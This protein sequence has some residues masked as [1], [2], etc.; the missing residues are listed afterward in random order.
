MSIR[1]R[2][3]LTILYLSA[4]AVLLA[5]LLDQTK[6]FRLIA[7]KAADLNYLAV[8]SHAP[9]EITLIVVDQRTMDAFSEPRMFWHGYYAEAIEAAAAAGA[10]VLGLDLAFAIPVEK[11]T[12][13]LDQR[14]AEAVIET[15]RV[16]P[17]ICAY[18]GTTMQKQADWPVPMNMAAAALGQ[19]AYVNLTADEDD[20]IRSIELVEAGSGDQPRMRSM[21]LE[22]ADRYLGHRVAYPS[23]L[24]TIR[25]A[26]PA[27]TIRRISLV[28]F[29]AAARAHNR[30]LLQSW[31]GG[32]A[33][34]LGTDEIGDRHA[35]PYYAFRVGWP[36][37]TAG[38]EI[39]ANALDTLL[40]GRFLR[41]APATESLALMLVV[42]L[43][44][45]FTTIFTTGWRLIMWHTALTATLM[46]GSHLA[47]RAGWLV[48]ASSLLLTAVIA[49]LL[50]VVAGS[51]T[52]T[53]N[54]DAL[55][56]AMRLF[57]GKEV[58]DDV[59]TTGMVGLSGRREFATVLFSDIRGFTAFS[60]THEP[61]VVVA[62][63]NAY[64]ST[65]TGLIV[66]H[67]GKVNKFIG[68]G[69]L[70]VFSDE[71]LISQRGNAAQTTECHAVRAIRCAIEMVGSPSA[72]ETRTGIHSG[73]VVVGNIG[74]SDKLENT[75]LGDTV[76]LASRLEGLNRQFST[77]VLFS[78]TTRE[79]LGN[80]IAA[81]LLGE[82]NVKGK[83][84]AVPVYTVA[85]GEGS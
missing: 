81:R 65:M 53:R 6:L 78:G 26:G 40:S 70:A 56:I 55:R 45:S 9:G 66:Q 22:L 13:G 12:P 39:H 50:S 1:S 75:V 5:W 8:P 16:M 37:N 2:R 18:A 68:D 43:L 69:I 21:A 17:V 83:S 71:P 20:F 59:E 38:V 44:F 28:D 14:L 76:N 31:V 79:L 7:L 35:T 15:S 80:R 32:K 34:L 62:Q 54:R 3:G 46:L 41:K 85:K 29:V 11:Y 51:L 57:V 25:Y 23:R 36:A 63:L 73:Y 61:E 4:A 84:T 30:G 72:F 58:A 74:S 33:V 27:G 47:F 67:G 10:K 77:N 48:P 19:M 64:L 49:F 24:M 52:I 60:E 42:A 82:A